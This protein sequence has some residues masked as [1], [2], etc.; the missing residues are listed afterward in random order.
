M[1]PIEDLGYLGEESWR[2]KLNLQYFGSSVLSLQWENLEL[3]NIQRK[4]VPY[5]WIKRWTKHF[6]TSVATQGPLLASGLVHP[7]KKPRSLSMNYDVCATTQ[8]GGRP[9]TINWPNFFRI[10][11]GVRD[12][13]PLL[14]HPSNTWRWKP[15]LVYRWEWKSYEICMV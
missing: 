15:T 12:F 9:K 6:V 8:G 7:K 3:N 13:G 11:N 10:A 5:H 14:G 1:L 2:E 4:R